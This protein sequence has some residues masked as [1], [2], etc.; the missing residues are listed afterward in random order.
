MDSSKMEVGLFHLRNFEF[1]SLSRQTQ[2]SRKIHYYN[3]NNIKSTDINLR[4]GVESTRNYS[5]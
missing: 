2:N 4:K 3:N 1:D 5:E